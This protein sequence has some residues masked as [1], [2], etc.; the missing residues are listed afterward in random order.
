MMQR[1]LMFCL[2]VVSLVAAGRSLTIVSGGRSSYVIAIPKERAAVL[3]TAATELQEHLRLATGVTLPIVDAE[4]RG[5]NVPAFIIGVDGVGDEYK[6]HD[7]I[8][9][10][11]VG[12]D[13]LLNGHKP[14]G[15]LYA[16]YEFLERYVGV[17]WWTSEEM[18]IPKVSMLRIE[19]KDY[20][21]APKIVCREVFYH[22]AK[23][24]VFASR[25][26]SNGHFTRIKPEY[27]GKMEI[28]GWCHTF[29]Q[30]LPPKKYYK[31]HPEWYSEINGKRLAERH[32][33]CLTNEEMR[34]EFVKVCL[35]HIKRKPDAGMISVSQ[36]D[37]HG[38][39]QC[40]NCLAVEEEE[41]SQSGP[42]IRFVNQVAEEIEKQYPD[43]F[44]E[45]LAYQ[46]TRQAPKK[47]RPRKNV[48]IRLCSIEMNF[49]QTLEQ[50]KDNASF[51]R[52]IEAW[53]AI[54]PN[55]YIWNYVTNFANYLLPQPNW[56]GLGPDVRFFEK[57][58]AIGLFEQGDAGCAAGDFV[59]PRQWILGKLMWNPKLNE[60]TLM[61][62]FFGAYYGAAGKHLLDYLDW[63]CDLVEKAGYNLR[64]FNTS[65]E[66]WLPSTMLAEALERYRKAEKA[67]AKDPIL[68]ERVRRE[69]LS[70]DYAIV[71]AM[72]RLLRHE[73]LNR[74]FSLKRMLGMEPMAF[75]RDFIETCEK[76]NVRSIR[77]G[78]RL[79]GTFE[80]MYKD[81]Q[82]VIESRNKVP[83]C[84]KGLPM[85]A[86]DWLLIGQF[87]MY[88][89]GTWCEF[90]DDKAA[91][92][93]RA[94]RM[95]GNHIQ[96]AVQAAIGEWYGVGTR[97]KVRVA[98]R[99]EGTATSGKALA[100][101]VYSVTDKKALYQSA[102]DAKDSMGKK[103]YV[104]ESDYFTLGK[105]QYVWFAPVNRDDVE[106]IYIDSII[107]MKEK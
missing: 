13:I 50:G 73:R 92:T 17:R 94:A 103:Y 45:T 43:F 23:E 49:A 44:I 61:K 33:L 24:G 31:E 51:K 65:V 62:E 28:I 34:K 91:S 19:A 57:H 85:D 59:R 12:R 52:D 60:K 4:S 11:F 26:R 29:Y 64:C 90:V 95:F 99:T 76:H 27:G 74:S 14:R 22:G 56:R 68:R 77:E 67:V 42:L 6:K 41:G 9:I 18:F 15:P 102:V 20:R 87:T 66:G 98:V 69:R 88:K 38:R 7:E 8:D 83:A 2:G 54:A 80:Q 39:C 79:N 93:G 58:N 40:K 86:W 96:W 78:R 75:F 101:G 82:V 30:F 55:L 32:Q 10:R 70:L 104:V 21:Y 106:S 100:W 46:Y 97:W 107:L 48:V 72:G 63:Q 5:R 35:G 3:E 105:N 53:S 25:L 47:T 84:C 1:V 36:N 37:W 16:V 71:Q 89:L 81:M